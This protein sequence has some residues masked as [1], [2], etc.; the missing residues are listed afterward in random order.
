MIDE[1]LL[2]HMREA[3]IICLV[4]DERGDGKAVLIRQGKKSEFKI[5]HEKEGRIRMVE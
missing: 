1:K 2:K 3:Q 5:K 4:L